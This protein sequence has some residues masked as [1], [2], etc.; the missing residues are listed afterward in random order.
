MQLSHSRLEPQIGFTKLN[1]GLSTKEET[2]KTTE[3]S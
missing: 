2:V 1:P 3:K